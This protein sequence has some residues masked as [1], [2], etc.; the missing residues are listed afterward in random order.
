VRY[1]LRMR[2]LVVLVAVAACGGPSKP[3]AAPTV[4][5]AV[6][7]AGLEAASL[8]DTAAQLE[9]AFPVASLEGDRV[10]LEHAQVESLPAVVMFDVSGGGLRTVTVAFDSGCDVLDD[11]G[12]ALDAELGKRSSAEAGIAAWSHAGWDIALYCATG[13]AGRFPRLDVRPAAR[14]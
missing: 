6:P 1:D 8:G 2:E 5:G 14:F 10:W 3:A 4:A 11:L 13:S 7:I 9:A 12:H